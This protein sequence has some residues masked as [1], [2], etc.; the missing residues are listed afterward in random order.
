[1]IHI[2]HLLN[3]GK[4][5]RKKKLSSADPLTIT[6]MYMYISMW[7]CGTHYKVTHSEL[8]SGIIP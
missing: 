6:N 7:V 3:T 5:M 4:K 2:E 8:F 1:M